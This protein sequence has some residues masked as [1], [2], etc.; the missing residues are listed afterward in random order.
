LVEVLLQFQRLRQ[1]VR[2]AIGLIVTVILEN[3]IA[4]GDAFV[5]DIGSRVIAGGGNELSDYI[6]AFMAKGATKGIIRSGSLHK[7]PCS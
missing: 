3:R 6:L 2:S 4:Y 1:L 5:A 7:P